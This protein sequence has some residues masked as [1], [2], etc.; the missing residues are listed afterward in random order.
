MC[1]PSSMGA[2]MSATSASGPELGGGRCISCQAQLLWLCPSMRCVAVSV[3]RARVY[4]SNRRGLVRQAARAG[5]G[6]V[7]CV[8]TSSY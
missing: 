6:Y 5:C 4:V 7:D 1:D 8:S 3:P 2:G